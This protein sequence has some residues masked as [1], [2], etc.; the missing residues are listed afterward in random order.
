MA[1]HRAKKHFGQHF[2][3][4]QYVID[5]IVTIF[6][7][8]PDEKIIEIGP[9]KGALTIPLL[10]KHHELDVIE[11]DRELASAISDKCKNVGSLKVHCVDVLNFDFCQF[12]NKRVRVIGNLPYNISTPVIFHL[13]KNH[14]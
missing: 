12:D 1:Y 8:K 6:D 14:H 4:D 5:Q 2:L 3:H 11:I 7:P 13:L 9:G 10:Q